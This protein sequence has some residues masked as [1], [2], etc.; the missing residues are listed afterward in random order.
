MTGKQMSNLAR[1]AQGPIGINVPVD[2]T[3]DKDYGGPTDSYDRLTDEAVIL[4][5]TLPLV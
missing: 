5:L 1:R 2:T 4:L 3:V